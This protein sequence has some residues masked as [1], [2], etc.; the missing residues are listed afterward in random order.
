M[1]IIRCWQ[2][3]GPHPC[4]AKLKQKDPNVLVVTTLPRNFR[5]KKKVVDPIKNVPFG[6]GLYHPLMM[7]LGM[8]YGINP[9]PKR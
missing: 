3:R 5:D 6:D 7:I 9:I 2:V 4:P 1:K 8:V